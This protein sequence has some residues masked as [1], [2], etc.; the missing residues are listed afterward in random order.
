MTHLVMHR[1]KPLFFW[2]NVFESIQSKVEISI[3]LFQITTYTTDIW[4]DLFQSR[5]LK[6]FWGAEPPLDPRVVTPLTHIFSLECPVSC[7]SPI[8]FSLK[9]AQVG[10]TSLSNFGVIFHIISCSKISIMRYLSCFSP[11]FFDSLGIKEHH[12][13]ADMHFARFSFYIRWALCMYQSLEQ[14]TKPA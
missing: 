6:R 12:F 10:F 4:L 8:L 2:W 11:F 1:Q 3:D 5:G 13:M 7:R 9:C 14:L